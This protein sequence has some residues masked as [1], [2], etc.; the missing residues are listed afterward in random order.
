[1]NQFIIYLTAGTHIESAAK[2]SIG[3]SLVVIITCNV[4]A[5]QLKVRGVQ[6]SSSEKYLSEITNICVWLIH[7]TYY[8]IYIYS[9]PPHVHFS[10]LSFTSWQKQWDCSPAAVSLHPALG[11]SR[12]FHY[13]FWF[14]KHCVSVIYNGMKLKS[15]TC[16]LTPL[17][18]FFFF[19]AFHPQKS[20]R[21]IFYIWVLDVYLRSPKWNQLSLKSVYYKFFS[22]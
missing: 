14:W 15:L 6:Y 19:S 21:I 1:M 13:L 16:E 9:P 18:I 4:W 12:C 8:Y 3:L 17:M 11:L 5:L 22:S 2:H 20:F 10:F 7:A